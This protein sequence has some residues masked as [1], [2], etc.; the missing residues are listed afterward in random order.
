MTGYYLLDNPP[1]SPQFYPSRANP[2]TWAVSVHTSE[3]P[4]GPGSALNLARFISQRTDPGSYA[5]VVDCETTVNLVPPSYTTFSVAVSG[6]NSR[7][8]AVCLAGRTAELS[9]TDPN[10]I[11]MI[12][13]AGTAIYQMWTEVGVPVANALEWIGIDALNRP[14]LFCHGDVQSYDRTDAWSIH[15]DRTALD[16]L[17]IDAIARNLPHPPN[18][19]K[20]P[21]N[22]YLMRG[23]N[24]PEVY[25]VDAGLGWKWNIPAGQ[26]PNVVWSIGQGGGNII[27]P[28]GATTVMI[29]GAAVWIAD[30]AFIDAIPRTK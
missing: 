3:G 29:E 9:P 27:T 6:V 17:L 8:W 13:R 24:A 25:L 5:V 1:G 10:T 28:Q 19:E 22:R 20:E 23:K 21:M 12:D 18:P 26:I 2:P 30:Q 4:T 11:A 7:T 14:G 16:A 15:P